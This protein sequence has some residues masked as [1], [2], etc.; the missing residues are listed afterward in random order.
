[1]QLLIVIV[2]CVLILCICIIL[3][4]TNRF[5]VRKYQFQNDKITDTFRFVLLSD[6]H[7]KSY[8]KNNDSLL[9]K[10]DELKPDAVLCAG[11]LLTAKPGRD[12]HTAAA[13]IS[14]LARNYPIYYGNGNH[15][16]RLK[17]YPE[18]YGSMAEDYEKELKNAGIEPLVNQR[19]ELPD[20]NIVIYGLE[21]GREYYKRFHKSKMER[22]YLPSLLGE[23][24]D[25]RC[26]IL[27][28]HNPEY[29][30][31]Y[32]DYG[33][34]FVLSGHVH[35]G[36][37]RIPVLGGVISPSLRIFPKY[38][39]GVFQEENGKGG[40][41]VMILS[42]GLGTHTIPIRFC[43]PGELIEITIFPGGKQS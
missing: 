3:Y 17:L 16:Y 42:R 10:I 29:F 30:Q 23:L 2:F 19:K 1:M 40:S 34:D 4:D 37:A 11:D 32:A 7:N 35:G 41:T 18:V 26:S 31:Q 15:E 27:L 28:A 21:I 20:K 5:V 9:K 39:G 36:V 8:G 13:L 33:A 14:A 25:Q 24:D 38:D 12:F 43:N 22:E 6:L